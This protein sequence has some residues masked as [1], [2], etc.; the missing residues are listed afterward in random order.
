MP[1]LIWTGT[2]TNVGILRRFE[3][4]WWRLLQ[5]IWREGQILLNVS[6]KKEMPTEQLSGKQRKKTHIRLCTTYTA[7]QEIR[8][9]KPK[10]KAEGMESC[11]QQT[12]E[13]DYAN[14]AWSVCSNYQR[15]VPV[16]GHLCWYNNRSRSG[17]EPLEVLGSKVQIQLNSGSVLEKG[18]LQNLVINWI[19]PGPAT[20]GYALCDVINDSVRSSPSWYP[21][22]LEYA[23]IHRQRQRLIVYHL[24]GL[25]AYLQRLRQM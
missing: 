18:S 6:H 8:Y 10:R 9:Y 13:G 16:S 12:T 24:T 3:Q 21:F 14:Q 23:P 4:V 7:R 11:C 15:H 1:N 25:W 2:K 19:A 17:I 22:Q 20:G 5:S